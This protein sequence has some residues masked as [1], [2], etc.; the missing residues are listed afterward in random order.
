MFVCHCCRRSPVSPPN[1]SFISAAPPPGKSK[2]IYVSRFDSATGK[3]TTPELAAEIENP[4]FLTVAPNERFLY[5]VVEVDKIG[6]KNTGGVKAYAVNA[7]TGKLTA[8]NQQ[9]SEGAGPCHISVDATGKTLLVANYGGGNIAALPIH[10]DGSL[11][12]ATDIIQHTGSSVNTN[13]QTAAHAHAIYPSPD[14]RFALN[15][16]LGLD[17]IFVYHFDADAGKLLPSNP[18]FVTVAPRLRPA[19]PDFFRR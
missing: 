11:G 1:R 7:K 15:C 6:D 14:N 17:K 13:R 9:N 12:A 8:L 5:A 19:S 2:G 4:T 18:P 3:L 10:A 16:D